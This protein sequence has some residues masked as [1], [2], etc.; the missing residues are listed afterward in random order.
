M[1]KYDDMRASYERR[2]ELL[3]KDIDY[4]RDKYIDLHGQLCTRSNRIG[5][6]ELYEELLNKLLNIEDDVTDSLFKF[7]GKYYKP[8]EFTLNRNPDQPDTLTVDFVNYPLDFVK[9]KNNA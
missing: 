6:M 5:K 4:W 9:E 1:S 2:I 8:V 7:D 3:Q